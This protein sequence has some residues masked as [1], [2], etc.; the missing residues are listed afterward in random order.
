MRK[1]ALVICL[2]LMFAVTAVAQTPERGRGTGDLY[3]GYTHLSGDVGKNGW[4]ASGT[5]NFNRYAG[6]EGDIAGYYGS[7]SLLSINADNTEYSFVA[8]PKVRF[9]TQNPKFVPWAHLLFGLAHADLGTNVGVGDAD[10]AFNW[11]LGGG[12]DYV[13]RPQWAGRVK[14]DLYHTDYFSNGDTHLRL[15]FGIVYRWGGQ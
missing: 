3:F 10:T 8:G 11:Q 12:V 5:W 15:G 13:F 9:E 4:N 7:K 14:A 2:A 6:V 1:A